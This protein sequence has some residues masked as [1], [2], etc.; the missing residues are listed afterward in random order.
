MLR[1]FRR[2]RPVTPED[3]RL[4]LPDA[5]TASAWGISDHEWRRLTDKDRQHARDNI[6]HARRHTN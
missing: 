4:P 1:F 2:Q 6:T 3:N 5:L